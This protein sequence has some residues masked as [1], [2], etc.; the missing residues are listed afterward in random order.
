MKAKQPQQTPFQQKVAA[1][2][3]AGRE[4]HEANKK[5]ERAAEALRQ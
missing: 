2:H 3:E 1:W 5:L 4:V